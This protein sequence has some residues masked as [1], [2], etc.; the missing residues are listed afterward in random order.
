MHILGWIFILANF[1]F[2]GWGGYYVLSDSLVPG[3]IAGVCL[4]LGGLMILSRLLAWMSGAAQHGLLMAD[5]ESSG[6]PGRKRILVRA[7]PLFMEGL[8]WLM[9]LINVG[10]FVSRYIG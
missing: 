1:I 9:G 4:L 6:L 7:F 3:F 5:E 10:I 2:A 8:I